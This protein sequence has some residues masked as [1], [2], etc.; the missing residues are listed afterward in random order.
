MKRISTS[1]CHRQL[2]LP[3]VM[4]YTME[5][6]IRHENKKW[7]LAY[8]FVNMNK[9]CTLVNNTVSLL[10][11]VSLKWTLKDTI[12]MIFIP[13][14]HL[15]PPLMCLCQFVFQLQHAFL[16]FWEFWCTQKNMVPT[17]LT[18]AGVFWFTSSSCTAT[19]MAWTHQFK[20]NPGQLCRMCIISNLVL[21]YSTISNL[22]NSNAYEIYPLRYKVSLIH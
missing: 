6:W 11:M 10:R 22:H 12:E 1:I 19:L 20:M 16:H 4:K 21:C 8:N 18:R 9:I 5:P 17:V 2:K 3:D 7:T 14:C 13:L 15:W